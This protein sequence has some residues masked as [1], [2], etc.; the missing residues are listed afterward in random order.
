M[1]NVKVYENPSRESRAFSCGVGREDLARLLIPVCN[2]FLK[3]PKDVSACVR[4][5]RL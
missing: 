5:I 1:L 3:A 4:L 2:C